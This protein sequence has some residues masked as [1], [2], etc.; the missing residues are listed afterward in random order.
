MRSLFD[1]NH[2]EVL[3]IARGATPEQIERSYRMALATY[4]DDS[5]ASYSVFSEGDSSAIRERIEIAYRVLG[6][7]VTR[8]EYDGTLD[9]ADDLR[10]ESFYEMITNPKPLVAPLLSIEEPPREFGPIAEFEELDNG[11]GNFDGARLRRYRLRCGMELEDIAGITKINNSYLRAIEEERFGDL[12]S[13]VYVRGFVTALASTLG[14]DTTT[15]ATS[16]MRLY[17]EGQ[18]SHRKSRFF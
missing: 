5:L 6:D 3:E 1:Q 16:Y 2:Y 4:A 12:P 14:L 15:V 17:D 11:T 8:R 13:K 9:G 18:E 7:D 10:D